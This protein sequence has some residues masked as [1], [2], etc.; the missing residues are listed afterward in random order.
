MRV[1]VLEPG[2]CPYIAFFDSS[3]EAVRKIIQGER[4]VSLPFGNDVIA[5]VTSTEQ[6]T[7]PFNRTIDETTYINGKALICGWDGERLREL[8]RK[9]ADRY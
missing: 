7:L 2:Y 6:D 8:S 4:N 9:Q 3:E 1:L 5:L